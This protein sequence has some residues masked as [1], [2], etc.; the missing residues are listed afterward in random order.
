M[1]KDWKKSNNDRK[2]GDLDL[3]D[4]IFW[5]YALIQE[6]I[7]AID[8]QAKKILFICNM[9]FFQIF[10]YFDGTNFF[11]NPTKILNCHCFKDTNYIQVLFIV[12]A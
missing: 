9:N 5:K 3:R 11:F 10:F 6:G 12:L 2:L 7:W 1:S 8:P 4:E